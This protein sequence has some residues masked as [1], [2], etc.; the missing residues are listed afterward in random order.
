MNTRQIDFGDE[1]RSHV[2]R[3][4]RILADA[5]ATTLGPGGRHAIIPGEDGEPVSTRDGASVARS[6]ELPDRRENLGAEL[7]RE[8]ALKTADMAG[9]GS[10]TAI[11]I[12]RGLI[13]E[14]IKYLAVGMDPMGMKRGIERAA[15]AVAE[16][17]RQ[18]ARPCDTPEEEIRTATVAANGDAV[19]GRQ[20]AQ[21]LARVGNDGSVLIEDGCGLFDELRFIEGSQI[22][23]GYLSP[24]FVS[25]IGRQLSV[26][27]EPAILLCRTQLETL[28]P[29]V[30][31]LDQLA[32]AG[33]QLLIVAADLSDEV[34][35]TLVTNQ[36]NGALRCCAIHAPGFGDVRDHWFDDLA[37]LTG[38]A[39][40]GGSADTPLHEATLERLGSAARAEIGSSRCTLVSPKGDAGRIAART[41]QLRRELD[42][43]QQ[44][45]DRQ[46]LDVRLR[47]LTGV[48]AKIGIGGASDLERRTRQVRANNAVQALR[49]ARRE[50]VLP[51]GGVALLRCQSVLDGL[52]TDDEAEAAGIRIM[53]RALEEPLRQIA[54]NAGTHAPVTLRIVMAGSG[55]YGFDASTGTYGPLL[56]KGILDPAMVTRSALQHAS[57]VATLLLTT[58]CTITRSGRDDAKRRASA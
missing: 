1:A 46:Q 28:T 50:G 30:P 39:V 18:M 55:D 6:I 37:V 43:A 47:A 45:N 35:A 8:A 33:R 24:H 54:G 19:L 21:A 3:G 29:M 17:L 40:L 26:L 2:L 5:V 36:R 27:Y 16:A 14:G 38:A 52:H 34:L 53:H 20:V 51:G 31:L 4:V 13:T 23:R 42:A 57:S 32:E 12:A 7:L 9:D 11:V 56:A 48:V 22:P 49:A 15:R 25:D 44:G 10:T 58:A 41:A